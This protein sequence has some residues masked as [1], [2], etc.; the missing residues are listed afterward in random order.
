MRLDS[1]LGGLRRLFL[2]A[3]LGAVAALGQA[4]WGLYGLTLVGL[5]A[6]IFLISRAENP[7]TAFRIGLA[8]GTG[9]FVLALSWI[10][11]PFLIDVARHGWMAPFALVLLSAGLGLFWAV[12][13]AIGRWARWRILGFVVSFTALEWLRGVILTGFPWAMIGHVWIG[14]PLDQLAAVIGPSG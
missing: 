12:A 11:E 7:V 5:A 4:P 8:A 3:L 14:T 10:V 2:A 13:A 1:W 6:V 9:H